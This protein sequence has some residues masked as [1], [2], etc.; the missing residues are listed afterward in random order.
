MSDRMALHAYRR[1]KSNMAYQ[2]LGI[3]W[4]LAL[5]LAL[6]LLLCGRKAWVLRLE[7]IH[8]KASQAVNA[9]TSRPWLWCSQ[10]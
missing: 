8:G 3:P 2:L 7:H 6:A 4:L 5:V 9:Y 1:G 10:R